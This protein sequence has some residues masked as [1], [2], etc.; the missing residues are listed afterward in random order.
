M[1]SPIMELLSLTE[2]LQGTVY[3]CCMLLKLMHSGSTKEGLPAPLTSDSWQG[4]AVT[5]GESGYNR[6]STA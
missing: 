2:C 6:K 4:R 1:T 3:V 5:S